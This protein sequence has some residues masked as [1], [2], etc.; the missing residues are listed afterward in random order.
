MS[1]FITERRDDLGVEPICRTLGV[2]AS[3]YYHRATGVRS[4]RTIEDERLT[5]HI[6]EIHARGRRV[7]AV[8]TCPVTG[9]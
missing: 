1:A 4:A 2:W 8:T 9:S 3:A 6:R 5:A 7:H